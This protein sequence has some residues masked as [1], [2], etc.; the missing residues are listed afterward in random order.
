M[1]YKDPN[2]RKAYHRTYMKKWYRKNKAKHMAMIR[3]TKLRRKEKIREW[4]ETDLRRDLKCEICG[5]KHIACI[6]FHHRDP[7]EKSFNLGDAVGRG[8][9]KETILAEVRKCN[10]WCS[11]CHRKFHY[12]RE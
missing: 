2:V 4:I 12:E 8:Y 1:S 5:E 6:D 9:S 7:D 10:I 11:N 3:V